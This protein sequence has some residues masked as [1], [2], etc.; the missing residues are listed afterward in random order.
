MCFP[1][2]TWLSEEI[3]QRI[4]GGKQNPFIS[5]DVNAIHLC[6]SWPFCFL[7]VLFPAQLL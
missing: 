1:N 2:S 4:A 7:S 6:V 3:A 5:A